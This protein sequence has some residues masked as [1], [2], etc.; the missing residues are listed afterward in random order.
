MPGRSM[1]PS[2]SNDRVSCFTAFPSLN[3]KK[4]YACNTH[5]ASAWGCCSVLQLVPANATWLPACA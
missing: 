1:I 3:R 2:L 5:V 4:T